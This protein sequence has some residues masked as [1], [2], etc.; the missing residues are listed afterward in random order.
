MCGSESGVEAAL[1][2]A[3]SGGHNGSL[4]GPGSPQSLV[5]AGGFQR[6]VLP[7][8]VLRAAGDCEPVSWLIDQGCKIRC[9]FSIFNAMRCN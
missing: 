2:R 8:S 6:V 7:G 9:A 1:L 4:R 5:E 3:D